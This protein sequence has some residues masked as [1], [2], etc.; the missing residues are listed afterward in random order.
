MDALKR[1]REPAALVVLAALIVRVALGVAGLFVLADQQ[2]S[3]SLWLAAPSAASLVLDGSGLVL[4]AAL[5]AACAVW[6]PTPHARFLTGAATVVAAVSVLLTLGLATAGLVVGWG[7]PVVNVLGLLVSLVPPT[8]I[9][10]GLALLWRALPVRESPATPAAPEA[11]VASPPEEAPALPTWAP[12]EASGAVWN[13]AGA[14][15]A[16]GAASSW[17]SPESGPGWD[18][19]PRGPASPPP[20]ALDWNLPPAEPAEDDRAPSPPP[21]APPPPWAPDPRR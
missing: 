15:A 12:H 14:A 18:P 13:T 6:E 8:V 19:V 20:A 21:E 16:G 1:W 5:V 17:G 3:G 2:A 11:A 4:L 9:A 10:V 7:G